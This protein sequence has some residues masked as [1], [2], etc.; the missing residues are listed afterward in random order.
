MG[1][2]EEIRF[3]KDPPAKFPLGK[4]GC[5]VLSDT[6][7]RGCVSQPPEI[8]SAKALTGSIRERYMAAKS[9]TP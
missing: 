5:R 3:R 4:R 9:P 1:D 7:R 2:E 6:L 8:K